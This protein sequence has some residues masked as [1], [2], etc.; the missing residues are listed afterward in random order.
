MDEFLTTSLACLCMVF[1]GFASLNSVRQLR[2]R[3]AM[4]VQRR[5]LTDMKTVPMTGTP[6]VIYALTQLLSGLV[7][8][9]GAAVG[10]TRGN[11]TIILL[12]FAVGWLIGTAGARMARYIARGEPE[13]GPVVEGEL[14]DDES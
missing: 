13:L 3:K 1:Y 9:A 2:Q 8:V 14:V 4:I 12:T 6:A 5:S 11:L 7:I 10:G